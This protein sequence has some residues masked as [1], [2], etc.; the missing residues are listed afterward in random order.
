MT[1]VYDGDGSCASKTVAGV[2]STYL[3]TLNPIIT[4]KLWN[5][6]HL[7]ESLFDIVFLLDSRWW[8]SRLSPLQESL[9]NGCEHWAQL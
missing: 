5:N 8:V 9:T 6:N 2:T 7:P 1:I 4:T 3:V